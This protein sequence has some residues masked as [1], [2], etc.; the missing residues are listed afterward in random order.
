MRISEFIDG[1]SCVS[2]RT[3]TLAVRRPYN[4]RAYISGCMKKYDE[5]AGNGLQ[6]RAPFTPEENA[7]II[8]PAAH[9]GGG[10]SFAELVFLARVTK[11]LNPRAVFEMGTYN[12]L[13]TAVFMLNSSAGTQIVTLDLPP[14]HAASHDWIPIDKELAATRSLGSV[15]RALDLNG[16]TQLLCDSMDFDPS[17]YLNAVDLGLIDAAHDVDHA[18]NDTLKMARMMSDRGIVLW[19]DYGG[20]GT[21]KPLARYLEG[22]SKRCTLYRIAD[23]S[24][25]WAPASE[26]RKAIG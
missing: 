6:S 8:I 26:L 21:L 16:Y 17:P 25:A 2:L 20:K 19:H 3:L 24:L 22:L 5:L 23:T 10:M 11:G 15:L 4:L 14:H 9:T 13:A 1:L 7:T 12:G 18:K